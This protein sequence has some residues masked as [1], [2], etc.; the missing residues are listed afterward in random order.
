MTGWIIG[1]ACAVAVILLLAGAIA[2]FVASRGTSKR[3]A[4]VRERMALLQP[5][6]AV[7]DVRR[8]QAAAAAFP[9]LADRA[10][11]AVAR[12]QRALAALRSVGYAIDALRATIRL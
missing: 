5:Q 6:S 2:A 10:R 7:E 4:A 8:L 9:E 3:V 1:G 12:L 11:M